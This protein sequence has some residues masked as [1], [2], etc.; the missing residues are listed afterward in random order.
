MSSGIPMIQIGRY[1]VQREI[2]RGGFGAVHRAW[3]PVMRRP[4]AIKVL[5]GV[6]DPSLL[7]RFRSEAGTTGNLNHKNI[8]TVYDYG[9]YDGQPYLVMQ[10]LEGRTLKEI[11]GG[12][13]N[14]P[15]FEKLRILT[16]IAEGLQYAHENGV[17][18]R[19]IKPANLMLLADGTVKILDFGIARLTDQEITR[20]T[21]TGFLVGTIEYMAPDQIQGGDADVLTDIFSYGVTC[22]EFL[23]GKQPFRAPQIGTVVY[24]VTTHEPASLGNLVP[25]CTEALNAVVRTAMAK[26]RSQRYSSLGDLLLDLAPIELAFRRKQADE[27]TEA[28][29]HFFE[30]GDF[31]A[32]RTWVSK[33]LDLDPTH[34]KGQ[35]LRR[36]I[37]Q[38]EDQERH[39]H[40]TQLISSAQGHNAQHR[41]DLAIGALEEALRLTAPNEAALRAGIERQLD[42]Y[43]ELR[44]RAGQSS[45]LVRQA[46]A[47][48]QRGDRATARAL[49]LRA[50]SLDPS[51]SEAAALQNYL[52]AESA[53]E[54]AAI[55]AE[56]RKRAGEHVAHNRFTD[57]RQLVEG[58]MKRFP[59]DTEFAGILQEIGESEKH[60]EELETERRR[61]RERQRQIDEEERSRVEESRVEEERKAEERWAAERLK[62]V[63]D[64]R[65][66]ERR[67][68]RQL[69]ELPVV[70]AATRGDRPGLRRR[71][72]IAGATVLVAGSLAVAIGILFRTRQVRPE[73]KVAG[74]KTKITQP[75]QPPQRSGQASEKVPEQTTQATS[76][77]KLPAS[78]PTGDRATGAMSAAGLSRQ[79]PAA[80]PSTPTP[81]PVDA[82]A[83]QWQSLQDSR[84]SAP[85]ESFVR[86]YPTGAHAELARQRIDQI[87]W[88]SVDKK[89][90]AALRAFAQE[91]S[92]SPHAAE[93]L[94]QADLVGVSQALYLFARAIDQRDEALLKAVWPGIPPSALDKWRTMFQN[95]RSVGIELHPGAPLIS[96]TSA[97]VECRSKLQQVYPGDSQTYSEERTMR[98]GLR[99]QGTDWQI[100]TVR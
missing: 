76:P 32:V 99:K 3:D 97:S 92:D 50:A 2:G 14:L 94:A 11:I 66:T 91:H 69:A 78:R 19:D 95:A 5:T 37:R 77:T 54:R 41:L 73:V 13:A 46:R 87:E 8:V 93:A 84:G 63:E 12:G 57:A 36:A 21:V 9:E 79:P 34:Q 23:S 6:T 39:Q 52:T 53:R 7:A 43:R 81:K 89:A 59:G 16:Q 71:P 68:A 56:V 30:V 22:Y 70:T 35:E 72:L 58:A 33:V 75:M 18:H 67:E 51:N 49:A 100:S 98:I 26:D 60:A 47:A 86:S 44:E 48:A 62:L 85:L 45:E 42:E 4:V 65:E 17:I 61:A 40:I 80:P 83:Q 10:L 31:E 64:E 90:P 25:E 1:E 88:D 15:V 74:A 82:E 27:W 20:Q 29:E 28:A 24:L 38:R 55:V 96:G